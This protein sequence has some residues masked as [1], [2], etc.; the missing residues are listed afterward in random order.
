LEGEFAEAE[1]LEVCVAAV[2]E[3]LEPG[4]VFGSEGEGAVVDGVLGGAGFASTRAHIV[5]EIVPG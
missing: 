1:G 2:D 5:T 3:S 4:W